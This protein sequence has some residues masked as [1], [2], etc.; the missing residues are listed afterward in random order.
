[1]VLNKKCNMTLVCMCILKVFEDEVD[2]SRVKKI[3][4]KVG[5][6]GIVCRQ[7]GYFQFQFSCK[8]IISAIQK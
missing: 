2:M 1:M 6:N 7:S 4:N 5:L 8:S 3:I